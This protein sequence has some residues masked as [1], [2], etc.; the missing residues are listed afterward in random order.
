MTTNALL[1]NCIV[2]DD[3]VCRS[4][5]YVMMITLVTLEFVSVVTQECVNLTFM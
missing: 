3:Y 4:V 2:C 1:P 5:V